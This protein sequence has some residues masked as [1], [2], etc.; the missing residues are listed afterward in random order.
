ML[1]GVYGFNR[2]ELE[3]ERNKNEQVPRFVGRA[4]NEPQKQSDN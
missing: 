2:M 1:C 3:S 4:S